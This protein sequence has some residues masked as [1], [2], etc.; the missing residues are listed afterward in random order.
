[1]IEIA[2]VSKPHGIHGDIKVRLYSQNFDDFATRG[3]AYIKKDGNC[4]RAGYTAL[5]TAP[6]FVYV[7]FDGIDTRS[8]AE[9][10]VGEALFLKRED[11]RPPDEGE[12]YVVDLIGLK[13]VDQEGEELGELVEI[14]QHGAA[15]VYVVSGEKDFMFPALKSVIQGVDIAAGVLRVNASALQEVSVYDDL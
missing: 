13:V 8:E 6:P 15:D 5:R 4:R 9:K 11:F 10:L 12:H 2:K 3:Y 7:H 1:M 14:L